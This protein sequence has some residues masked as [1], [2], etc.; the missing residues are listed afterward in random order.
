LDL[1]IIIEVLFGSGYKQKEKTIEDTRKSIIPKD[2]NNIQLNVLVFFFVYIC[3]LL[4]EKMLC[5]SMISS[6]YRFY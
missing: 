4:K 6:S 2:E 1:I 3:I 5:H